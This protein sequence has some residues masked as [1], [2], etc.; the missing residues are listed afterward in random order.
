MQN[1]ALPFDVEVIEFMTNSKLQA[2]AP[3]EENQVASEGVA[4]FFTAISQPEVSGTDKKQTADTPA[5]YLKFKTKDGK[6]L[7]TYLMSVL[8][9]PQKVTVGDKT[10]QVAL[11][12]KQTYRPYSIQLRKFSFDRYEGTQ[13]ARNFSSLVRVVDPE[14]HTDRE[15]LIKMNDPLRYRGETFYQQSFD[16]ETEKTTFLQVVRNPAWL[17]PYIAC[18]LVALGMSIHLGMHLTTFLARRRAA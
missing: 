14:Q 2:L 15:V 12:F 18:A 1:D 13:M 3:S 5:A 8:L 11:R 6:L 16:P 10:Y 17:L 7:G 4:L 9:H